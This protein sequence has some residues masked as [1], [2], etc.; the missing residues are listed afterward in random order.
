MSDDYCVTCDFIG[1]DRHPM[2]TA[3]RECHRSI[4]QSFRDI[5]AA[6]AATQTR[7]DYTLAG[8]SKEAP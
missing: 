4:H 5:A 6:F 2:V 1:P 7:D 8:P 3:V